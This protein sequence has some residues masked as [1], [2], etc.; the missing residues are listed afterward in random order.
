MTRAFFNLVALISLLMLLPAFSS[1][2]MAR[3]HY[4]DPG[5]ATNFS[6]DGNADTPWRDLQQI[7]DDD[8][9]KAGDRVI[10]ATGN[11]G[12]LLVE[13]KKMFERTTILAGQDQ[14]PVFEIV[15]IL[16]S[17]NWHLQG[18]T[19]TSSGQRKQEYRYHVRVDENSQHITVND[20]SIY[21]VADISDWSDVDWNE[22]AID[23]I[24]S[25][26]D[27]TEFHNNRI[28]NVNFGIT[29]YGDNSAV[30]NNH[31]ENFSGDG[32]RGLGDHALFEGNVVKNCYQVNRNHADG[33]QSWSMSADGVIAAGVVKDVI[34]RRNLILN[35]EDFDQPYRCELQGIGMFGGVYEDWII[36]NNIVIVDNFHGITVLGARNVRIQHNT[37]LD[38]DYF[39]PGPAAITIRRQN[40]GPPVENSLIANNIANDIFGDSEGVVVVGNFMDADFDDVFVD[41]D[42]G[43]YRLPDGSEAIDICA[44]DQK[45]DIDF[46]GNPRPIGKCADAG[47]VEYRD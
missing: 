16:G 19:V 26:G 18:L 9:V 46:F 1:L 2:S 41:I 32:L 14:K 28:K 27:Y 22:Q 43:D 45:V 15:D 5:A 13:N 3:D 24:F 25:A 20:F 38:V 33:F 31:I 40:G 21:T 12:R 6:G 17:S 34:L 4:V 10:L 30:V 8:I 44:A 29:I 23:G 11:Y 47:A 39:E 7:I 35:F 36:E 37:V 42:D